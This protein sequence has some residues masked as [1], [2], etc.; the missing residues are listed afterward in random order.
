MLSEIGSHKKDKCYRFHLHEIPRVVKFI[1]TESRTVVIRG[2]G[3]G[4]G[5]IVF[6]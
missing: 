1:E 4:N 2:W 3:R 5:E 6:D